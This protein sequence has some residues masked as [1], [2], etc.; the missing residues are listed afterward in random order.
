[1]PKKRKSKLT[2]LISMDIE[3]YPTKRMNQSF[4]IYYSYKILGEP[5]DRHI[6]QNNS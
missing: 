2:V 6:T 4:N 1:M 5:R 3:E